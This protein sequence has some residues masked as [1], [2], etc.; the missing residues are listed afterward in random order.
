MRSICSVQDTERMDVIDVGLVG[1]G[2]PEANRYQHNI[3]AATLSQQYYSD[4][5][6]HM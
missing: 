4:L 3:R 2:E 6:G 5:P 1:L